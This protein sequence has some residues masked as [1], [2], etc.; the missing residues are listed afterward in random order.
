MLSTGVPQA[1]IEL[2]SAKLLV[3]NKNI[4]ATVAR[5]SHFD[6]IILS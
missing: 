1:V 6:F 5:E 2:A 3:P 4:E